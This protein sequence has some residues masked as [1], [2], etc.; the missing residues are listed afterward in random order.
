M[1]DQPLVPAS[2]GV[3]SVAAPF[4]RIS[5]PVAVKTWR[6][7]GLE[8]DRE[9]LWNVAASRSC[10]H[11]RWYRGRHG[12]WNG[13]RHRRRNGLRN[14]LRLRNGLQNSLRN[15]CRDGCRDGYWHGGWYRQ[16]KA[17]G[18][19]VRARTAVG[20]NVLRAIATS[21]RGVADRE[22]PLAS[23]SVH[24]STGTYISAKPAS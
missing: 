14:W 10:W 12:C 19:K 3:Y 5:L 4:G 6:S 7:L 18:R 17:R 24:S 23:L 21:R 8:I 13:G 16:E 2:A 20:Q 11:W 22:P 9:A 15:G 1:I